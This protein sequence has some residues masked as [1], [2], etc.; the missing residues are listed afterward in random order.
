MTSKNENLHSTI[1]LN[2]KNPNKKKV[3][4]YT[5]QY[6]DHEYQKDGSYIRSAC[7]RLIDWKQ[8]VYTRRQATC[9]LCKKTQEPR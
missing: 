1:V 9:K 2:P 6:Q 4:H 5:F 7:G 3:K 8:I